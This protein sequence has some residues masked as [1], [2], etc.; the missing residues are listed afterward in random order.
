[1]LSFG[2]ASALTAA[3]LLSSIKRRATC[4][5]ASV[6]L[7]APRTTGTAPYRRAQNMNR[8]RQ[9]EESAAGVVRRVRRV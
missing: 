3:N 6:A 4:V 7:R 5:N 9:Q 8:Q 2:D 1:V